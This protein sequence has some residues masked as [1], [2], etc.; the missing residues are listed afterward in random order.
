MK[1]MREI[2]GDMRKILRVGLEAALILAVG[3]GFGRFAFTAIYPHMVEEQMLSV[4]T[5]S[6][7]ASA[8]YIGYLTGA[9]LAIRF[10]MEHAHKVCIVA[11]LGTTFCLGMQALPLFDGGFIALRGLA[12][13]FS[14]LAIVGASQWLLGQKGLLQAAPLLYAGVGLGI[15]LSAELVVLGSAWQWGSR[16]LWLMLA[17]VSLC[18]SLVVIPALRASDLPS[19][20]RKAPPTSTPIVL[21]TYPLIILY[22]LAGFGYIIT[23]TYM[24]LLVKLVLPDWTAGHLWAVFGFGAVPSC[25]IWHAVQQRLRSKYALAFNLSLQAVGVALPVLLHIAA[26]YLLSALLVGTAFMGTVTLVMPLAQRMAQNTSTN[27]IAVLT[28]AYSIGQIVGPLIAN[29]FYRYTHSFDY[30]LLSASF[31]LL[32]ATAFSFALALTE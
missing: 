11:L 12:G 24:P 3:M 21:R 30:S 17:V 19:H 5:G 26:G 9:L 16:Q 10:R 13:V 32:L 28:V 4:Q 27:L 18:I 22:G 14:A 1:V 2:D 6:F 25:F 20:S 23:A 29:T 7:A 15:A 31:A 8:N